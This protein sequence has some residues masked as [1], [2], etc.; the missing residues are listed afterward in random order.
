MNEPL[1]LSTAEV[2]ALLG[3][4][5]PSLWRIRHSDDTFP[6][7]VAFGPGV[8]KANRYDRELVEQWYQKHVQ[9]ANESA[10]DLS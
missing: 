3:I 10:T 2:C 5:K 8:I 7:P 9:A 6:K 1:T 4:S